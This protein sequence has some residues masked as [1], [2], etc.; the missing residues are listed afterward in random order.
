MACSSPR[1][2]AIYHD[3]DARYV[4]VWLACFSAAGIAHTMPIKLAFQDEKLRAVCENT[5][6][7]K[8]KYGEVAGPSI[9]ARLADL[10]AA[11]SPIEFVELGFGSFDQTAHDRIV[12]SIAGGYRMLAVANNRPPPG[13]PGALEWAQVTRMKI[14]SIER[15]NEN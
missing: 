4:S 10:R 15:T 14:V 11:K 12:I 9:H 13:A 7:A 5:V 3:D 1:V 6:S 8:R 2:R